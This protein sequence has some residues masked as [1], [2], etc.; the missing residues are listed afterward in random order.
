MTR[1]HL[2]TLGLALAPASALAA[3]AAKAPPLHL[4]LKTG[5]GLPPTHLCVITGAGRQS[6]T[7]G[8]QSASLQS[9]A[10]MLCR[11]GGTCGDP[12]APGKDLPLYFT[13]RGKVALVE[14]AAARGG[15][16]Q[17]QSVLIRSLD[18]LTVEGNQH[19][20]SYGDVDC[21]PVFELRRFTKDAS[22]T[23][24]E[25]EALLR[26]DSDDP[27]R[28][29]R[30]LVLGIAAQAEEVYA[31]V[32][33]SAL[34][35]SGH[36]VRIELSH[37]VSQVA[38]VADV[39]GG[40]YAPIGE[41]RFTGGAVDLALPIE[42]RCQ[43]TPVSIPRI[44]TPAPQPDGPKAPPNRDVTIKI[45]LPP[46][47]GPDRSAE[48]QHREAHPG[49]DWSQL[50]AE[51]SR[52]AVGTDNCK[53]GSLESAELRVLIP[54]APDRRKV[55]TISEGRAAGAGRSDGV[56]PPR[57]ALQTSWYGPRPSAGKSGSPALTMSVKGMS[58]SWRADRCL[59]PQGACPAAKIASSGLACGAERTDLDDEGLC[60]YRCAA[61]GEASIDFPTQIAFTRSAPLV[62]LDH[63]GD[64]PRKRG[65]GVATTPAA[66]RAAKKAYQS[67]TVPIDQIEQQ[68]EGYVDADERAFE[69]DTR[70]WHVPR[71]RGDRPFRLFP[72]ELHALPERRKR[73]EEARVGE[74]KQREETRQAA[75]RARQAAE[76]ELDRQGSPSPPQHLKD[77]LK[78]R[79]KEL[80]RLDAIEVEALRAAICPSMPE[81]D[82][83]FAVEL[84][85]SDHITQR[86]EIDSA[87]L[88]PK[89]D[90]AKVQLPP[91]VKLPRVSCNEPVQYRY[92]GQRGYFS[93]S[94]TVADGALRL[95]HPMKTARVLHFTITLLPLAFQK[96]LG[97]A[98]FRTRSPGILYS[99]TVEAS[100]V[101]LPRRHRTRGW[102]LNLDLTFVGAMRPY[103]GVTTDPNS[104]APRTLY[105][106]WY[107]GF[108][109]LSPWLGNRHR[110]HY[111]G[112]AVALG[113]G[114]QAGFGYPFS[115]VDVERLGGPVA[116]GAF[117]ADLRLRLARR[118]E[119]VVSPRLLFGDEFIRFAT[120]FHG[121][122]QVA[123][124][125]SL[126]SLLLPVGFAF[127]W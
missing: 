79:E 121:Q 41:V 113:A 111:S 80:A 102:R 91:V 18:H 54:Y 69:L 70:A 29:G 45:A 8:V 47:K 104:L 25:N 124:D 21:T 1:A 40:F 15:A 81:R 11:R 6:D 36:Q 10:P 101:F 82:D 105:A 73:C 100:F 109:F 90:P 84:T 44:A 46:D 97:P 27:S 107:G 83:I 112:F 127:T 24:A 5:D 13:D 60:H 86:V 12:F 117:R 48:A 123:R 93:D 67:W 53:T 103:L 66:D 3:P 16:I 71:R 20:C 58:F 43:W 42:P 55:L 65:A 126:V 87:L 39:L 57:W 26:R 34:Q 37:N 115:R 74:Q 56:A 110:E 33:L 64:D 52:R 122:P 32:Q 76:D 61:E 88:C 50:S 120:D 68:L 51:A 116:L 14:E 85:T 17:P 28:S 78:S 119:L 31:R 7:L 2:L 114:I 23:C 106:R 30:V 89:G 75:L 92:L 96:V 9:L 59:Y 4:T 95:P 99:P 38:L 49:V 125:R 108:S 63:S 19:Q 94:I 77:E 22:I 118:F 72:C 35:L 62:E 98:D